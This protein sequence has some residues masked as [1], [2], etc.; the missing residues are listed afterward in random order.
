M[1]GAGDSILTWL[2]IPRLG[3]FR[4]RFPGTLLR[5]ANLRSTVI[6][7]QLLEFRIDFGIARP[8]IVPTNLAKRPLGKVRYRLCIPPAL[9]PRGR[10]AGFPGLLQQLPLVT[11]GSDA[12]F[13]QRLLESADQ[14]RAPLN[15]QLI[16]DSFPQAA[17]AVVSGEYAGI[18]PSH[19]AVDLEK[20][21]V[22]MT[23]HP[24]LKAVERRLVLAWNP[25]LGRMRLNL[26]TLSDDLAGLFKVP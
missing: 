16:T 6:V 13:M 9:Q 14:H 15:I 12:T 20:A 23:D 24:L 25:R 8:E 5:L 21:G 2:V 26:P 17:R 18:L 11:L 19:A 4:K 1:L 10:R 22:G 7:E 3:K